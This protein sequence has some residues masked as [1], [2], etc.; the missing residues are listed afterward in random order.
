MDEKLK[1]WIDDGKHLPD[2]LKD[3]HDQKDFFKFLHE[4]VKVEEH[5][6]L[7]DINWI[8]GHCYIID[9]FLRKLA[10]H[11]YTIQ[12]SKSSQNFEDLDEAIKSHNKTQYEI[13][14]KAILENNKT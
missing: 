3:F 8:Q 2:F 4:T 6:M 5:E 1:Q 9:C 11:G 10:K 14:M 13:L 12:K 7:K